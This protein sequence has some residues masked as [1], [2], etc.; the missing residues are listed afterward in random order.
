MAHLRACFWCRNAGFV[1][2]LIVA[3]F[4]SVMAFAAQPKPVVPADPA[5]AGAGLFSK[6]VVII[7]I[8]GPIDEIDA[9]SVERR[10]K[11]AEQSKADAIVIELNTPG[12]RVDSMLRISGALKRTSVPRT[13][14]WVKPMAYSAGTYIAHACQEIVTVRGA[15]F[16]DAAPVAAMPGVGLISMSETERSK[17]VAPVL[18]DIVDSARR[19]GYDEKFVQGYVTL[20]VELWWIENPTTGE[21]LFVDR[22]EY[23]ALFDAEPPIGSPRLVSGTRTDQAT[24]KAS[25]K[26]KDTTGKDA[27]THDGNAKLE[28]P[29]NDFTPQG[30]TLAKEDLDA[31]RQRIQSPSGR[32]VLNQADRGKWKLIEYATDGKGLIAMSDADMIHYGIARATVNTDE[33][34]K[35]YLNAEVMVRVDRAWYEVLASWFD[36]VVVKGI[37]IVLILVCLLIEF[38][39]PGMIF[40]GAAAV[41]GIVLLMLPSVLIGLAGWW[42]L[43]AVIVGIVLLAVEFY[44]LPG[45][46]IAGALGLVLLLGGLV[47]SFA[48]TGS[49]LFPG[50]SSDSGILIGLAFVLLGLTT[51]GVVAYAI[52]KS[53]RTLP[54]FRHLVLSSPV[55]EDQETNVRMSVVLDDPPAELGEQGVALTTLRPSGKAE[56]DGR[57]VDVVADGGFIA[58]GERVRVIAIDGL[59]VV[60]ERV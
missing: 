1:G 25:G 43:V 9:A 14:A 22:G 18:G 13:V 60:V 52:S 21:R 5:K 30:I 46:G 40:P 49:S 27:A 2:G 50:A 34:L 6:N 8:S 59:R 24:K 20:G 4:T 53:S 58:Q 23:R 31:A 19:N 10:I 48:S 55:A 54:V 47:M 12:G 29:G 37:L 28:L 39:H 56:M 38:L 33:E 16:G 51:A 44:I 42:A 45:F 26:D 3:L 35:A 32:R 17:A 7:T 36:G 57:V 15:N 11:E 41:L